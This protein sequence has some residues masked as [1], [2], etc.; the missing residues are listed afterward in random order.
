MNAGN[1]LTTDPGGPYNFSLLN[2]QTTEVRGKHGLAYA[3]GASCL[4]ELKEA[5][6]L[7]LG[8]SYGGY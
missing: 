2:T 5:V 4:T 3:H 1:L 6:T 7:E 8:Y